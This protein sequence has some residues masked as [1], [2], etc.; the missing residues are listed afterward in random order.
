MRISEQHMDWLSHPCP[1][2]LCSKEVIR[3]ECILV[4]LE[5]VM[6]LTVDC[7]VQELMSRPS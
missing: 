1:A 2:V 5:C 4:N 6:L 3:P 7:C